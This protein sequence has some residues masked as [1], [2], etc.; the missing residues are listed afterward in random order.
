MPKNPKEGLVNAMA[1]G[2]GHPCDG[3]K[4]A[5]LVE[6]M[7]C[8]DMI[9]EISSIQWL[10]D[11]WLQVRIGRLQADHSIKRTTEVITEGAIN[12]LR[13]FLDGRSKV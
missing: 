10:S 8:E 13:K 5:D 7:P 2:M 9:V 12:S 6:V 3:L 4:A 11:E 1:R